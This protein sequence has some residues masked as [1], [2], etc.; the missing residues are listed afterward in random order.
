MADANL[1]AKRKTDPGSANGCP[2]TFLTRMVMLLLAAGLVT[3]VCMNVYV[4][5]ENVRLRNSYRNMQRSAEATSR[6][7]QFTQRLIAELGSLSRTDAETANLL[8]KHAG[9][10]SELGLD[11]QDRAFQG[12]E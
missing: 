5:T 7:Y 12:G 1:D 8:R 9:A 2:P 6:L 4:V 3:S 11:S 10:I